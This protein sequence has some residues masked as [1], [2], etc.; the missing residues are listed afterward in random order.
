MWI[1]LYL[2]VHCFLYVL[3]LRHIR[4][5]SSEK[6]I[7]LYHAFSALVIICIQLGMLVIEPQLEGVVSSVGM[8]SL[9]GIYS[10]SFLELWSLAE[11]GYSLNI[12]DRVNIAHVK[13]LK[14][15]LADL[16]QIGAFKKEG[17]IESLQRLRLVCRQG[18]RFSLTAL[19]RLVALG[20]R[21]VAWSVNVKERG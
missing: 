4:L 3:V 10:L 20:L 6:V 1:L 5:F 8:I 12:L 2:V 7:F 16:H 13:G 9:H 14:V 18:Q 15:K 11:G 19:G 17:R 21:A